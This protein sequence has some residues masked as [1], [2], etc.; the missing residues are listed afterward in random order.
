MASQKPKARQQAQLICY[1]DNSVLRHVV[2]SSYAS[3]RAHSE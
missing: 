1:L 3:Q 2:E